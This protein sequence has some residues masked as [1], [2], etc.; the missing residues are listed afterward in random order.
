M[1]VSEILLGL[2]ARDGKGAKDG[3]LEKGGKVT[4]RKHDDA[5]MR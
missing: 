3:D 4:F 1:H 2:G 5:V